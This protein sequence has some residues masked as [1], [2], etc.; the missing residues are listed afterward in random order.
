M[1]VQGVAQ[2][3]RRGDDVVKGVVA[4]LGIRRETAA[5]IA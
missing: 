5:Q 1:L 4:R 3:G 2:D